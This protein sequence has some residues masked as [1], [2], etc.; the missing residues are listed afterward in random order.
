LISNT[1]K[2]TTSRS[3]MLTKE[4]R[5]TRPLPTLAATEEVDR[6][7][8]AFFNALEDVTLQVE[9][10][11]NLWEHEG[12]APDQLPTHEQIGYLYLFAHYSKL[13]ADQ[14]R[15]EAN[16]IMAALPLLESTRVDVPLRLEAEG[17]SD[18]N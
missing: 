15:D 5:R 13:Q 3:Q 11:A 12:I 4:Q 17:R 16:R 2:A 18:G 10:V 6:L 14:I 1:I 7:G 8:S 9:T